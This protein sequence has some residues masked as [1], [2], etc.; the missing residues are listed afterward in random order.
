MLLPNKILAKTI[1]MSDRT[2]VQ[3][4]VA[5]GAASVQAHHASLLT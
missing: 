3:G 4:Q 1:V 5:T 2:L